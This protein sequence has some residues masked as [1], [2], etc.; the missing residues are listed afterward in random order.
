MSLSAGGCGSRSSSNFQRPC[1]V[2]NVMSNV[3]SEI[4]LVWIESLMIASVSSLTTTGGLA[5]G[6]VD[7]RDLA[8][9]PPRRHERL[10]AADLGD[11]GVERLARL[12]SRRR[13]ASCTRRTRGACPSPRPRPARARSTNARRGGVGARRRVRRERSAAAAPGSSGATGA[14]GRTRRAR[15]PGLVATRRRERR[16]GTREARAAS[17]ALAS[18]V[19]DSRTA[20]LGHRSG[21]PRSSLACTPRRSPCRSPTSSRRPSTTSSTRERAALAKLSQRHPREPRAPLRGAQGGDVD[22]RAPPGAR[23]RGRARRR[24]A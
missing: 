11:R 6:R 7:L 14:L 5:G 21:L 10:D 22:R 13:S 9:G 17:V 15:R 23:L 8:V 4:S 19:L 2:W 20:P 1:S 3:P 16:R 24:R 12:A 18:R